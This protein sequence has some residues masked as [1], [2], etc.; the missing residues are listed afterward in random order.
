MAKDLSPAEREE[1]RAALADL[2]NNVAYQTAMEELRSSYTKQLIA[3]P[4]GSLTSQNLHAKL[5][6]LEDLNQELATMVTSV[7]HHGKLT[8]GN[9]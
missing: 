9:I 1:V 8:R 5:K 3:E 2:Q 7:R 6:V 4:V